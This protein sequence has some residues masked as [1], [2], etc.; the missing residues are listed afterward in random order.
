MAS[1]EF[2]H[3]RKSVRLSTWDVVLLAAMATLLLLALI[4]PSLAPFDPTLVDFR[5]R[6][7][8]P[9]MAHPLGTDWMGRDQLSR[10]LT[11]AR[12]SL[13]LS[14]AISFGAAVLGVALG[15]LSAAAGP[16]GDKLLT[17]LAEVMQAF[18]ELVAAMAIAALF[19]PSIHNLVLAL[20]V[21]SWMRYARLTR[22][23]AL[24]IAA[25]DHV[26]LAR[27]AGVSRTAI[28]GRHILPLLLPALLVM[29]TGGWA[30]SILSVSALG[31][32]G[33]GMQ[34]PNPEWGAMLLDARRYIADAPHLMW[35]PG[36]AIVISVL[37]ISLAGDRLRDLFPN[38]E[39]R[40]A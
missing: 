31:F 3:W 4:G 22:G 34:P 5:A 8:M 32:L 30:R 28:A 20:V 19:G 33:F 27:L 26:A 37:A 40:S 15:L 38:D 36:L 18:P 25:R 14:L 1:P 7:Q 39:A 9:S 13:G 11:G 29:W 17:R 6:M 2:S 24:A 10:L 21:T 12:A 16:L 23:L 35:A